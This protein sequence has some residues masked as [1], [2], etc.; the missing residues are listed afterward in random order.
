MNE[1][2][3]MD[4]QRPS[5]AHAKKIRRILYAC[6]AFF[7]CAGRKQLTEDAAYWQRLSLVRSRVLMMPGEEDKS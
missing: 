2:S 4:I 5:N 1:T 6:V 3:T 7:P